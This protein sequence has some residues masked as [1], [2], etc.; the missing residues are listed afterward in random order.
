[1][2]PFS[3]INVSLLLL[4]FEACLYSSNFNGICCES[5]VSKRISWHDIRNLTP[6]THAYNVLDMRVCQSKP[7]NNGGEIAKPDGH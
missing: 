1:M 2:I 5:V 7:H 3:F 6:T 4:K